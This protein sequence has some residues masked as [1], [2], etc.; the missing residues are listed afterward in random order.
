MKGVQWYRLC[1]SRYCVMMGCIPSMCLIRDVLI[2][3]PYD[4]SCIS[5]VRMRHDGCGIPE[6]VISRCRQSTSDMLAV[7]VWRVPWKNGRRRGYWRVRVNYLSS[8]AQ[9][10][11]S[12]I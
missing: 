12:A 11:G 3:V 8:I 5:S 2:Q 9:T 6:G 4:V 1:L 10:V 7:Q